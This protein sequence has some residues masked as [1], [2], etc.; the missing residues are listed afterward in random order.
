MSTFTAADCRY[1]ADA[2]RL[3]WRGRYGAHPNPRVGCV[4]VAGTE[5]VG[6]GWHARAGD[7]H[8]EIHALDDAGDRARGATAYVSLEPCRHHGKTGPCTEALI[9]A[10]VARVVAASRDPNPAMAGQGLAE[11]SAA[12]IETADGLLAAEAAKLN[13]GFFRRIQGGRPFVRLKLAASLDGATAMASGESRWI[14]GPAARRD[15]QRL[16]AASGAVLTGI[17]TVRD[18][19]PSLNVRD[20][21][22]PRQPLRVVL[23]SSLSMAPTARMLRLDGQTLVY[24]L[25]DRRKEALEAAGATVIRVTTNLLFIRRP[26]SW[27]TRLTHSLPRPAGNG[28][29]TANRLSWWTGARSAMTHASPPDPTG[30]H[31]PAADSRSKKKAHVYRNHQG[32]WPHHRHSAGGGRSAPYGPFTGPSLEKFRTW[33]KHRR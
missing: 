15:V 9:R 25:D 26:I 12:G 20:V 5:I 16:R 11:L 33:R 29:P 13:E 10:G 6:R 31:R 19:D 4:I 32:R 17:G 28:W 23:D 2:I 8:A 22:V 18:V 1:M 3:A 30:P 24:C 14:T 27:E 21:D 7:A